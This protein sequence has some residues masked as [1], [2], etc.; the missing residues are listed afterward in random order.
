MAY[1]YVSRD[2]LRPEQRL[3]MAVILRAFHDLRLSNEDIR[4]EVLQWLNNRQELATW[5]DLAEVD[6]GR[7]RRA[8]LQQLR[9]EGA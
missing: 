5:C 4:G 7:F 2:T 1:R 8:A 3:G 6:P 9:R